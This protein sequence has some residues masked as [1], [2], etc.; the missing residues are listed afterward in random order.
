MLPLRSLFVGHGAL[1]ESMC[2]FYFGNTQV[3]LLFV[4]FWDIV[5]PVLISR[6][7]VMVARQAHNL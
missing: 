5:I 4:Y 2:G 3:H 7:R 1:R 6:G